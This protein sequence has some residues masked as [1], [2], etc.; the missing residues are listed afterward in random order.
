M[1]RK[2]ILL[3]TTLLCMGVSAHEMT[4]TYPTWG[5]SHVEGVYKTRI[6]LF[7]KR[8]DV[9]FYEI[10]VF[11]DTWGNVPFVSQYRIVHMPYLSHVNIDIYVSLADVSKAKYVCSISKLRENSDKKPLVSSRICSKFK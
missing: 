10:G 3:C 2:V 6:A 7:N 1:Y 11:D 9:E 4:P 8:A 5:V